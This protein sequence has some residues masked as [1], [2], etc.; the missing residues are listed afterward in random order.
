VIREEAGNPVAD[1]A[2]AHAQNH[3]DDSDPAVPAPLR[4]RV[5]L[6]TGGSAGIGVAIGQTLGRLGANVVLASRRQE[7]V[8]DVA[9]E[10]RAAGVN[11]VGIAADVRRPA[12]V[13]AL[14]DQTVDRFGKLDILVNNAGASFGDSFKRGPLLELSDDDL[15]EAYRLNVVGAFLCSRSA[16]PHLRKI[17]GGVIVNIGSVAGVHAPRGLAAY[18]AS[19]AALANMTRSMAEEWAPEVRV[20][21]VAPGHIDTP[22]VSANRTGERLAS[23]LRGIAMGRLGTPA[24]VA[25]AVAYLVS[26]GAAW[27]T[28]TMLSLHGG[29]MSL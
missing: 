18:G 14:V 21:G 13:H 25:S 7:A 29:E 20:C 5:A 3:P 8:D 22:R 11:A 27:N 16:V 12:E 19:K 28:G 24:D 9:L 10:L 4:D 6:V 26:S 1:V 23:V 2:D 17:E 15:I